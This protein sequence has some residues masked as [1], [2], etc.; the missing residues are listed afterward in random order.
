MYR[1]YGLC[2]RNYCC[3]LKEQTNGPDRRINRGLTLRSEP[4]SR[5]AS[6]SLRAERFPAA[7]AVYRSKARIRWSVRI[8][9]CAHN[10][11]RA[12]VQL[13]VSNGLPTSCRGGIGCAASFFR[14]QPRKNGQQ[15]MG[16]ER[17]ENHAEGEPDDAHVRQRRRDRRRMAISDK[18]LVR[19]QNDSATSALASSTAPRSA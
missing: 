6:A 7:L 16:D 13:L 5:N 14:E 18:T 4:S 19:S 15:Y 12:V 2:R 17:D 9:R 11:L 10:R 3:W 8:D 1:Y